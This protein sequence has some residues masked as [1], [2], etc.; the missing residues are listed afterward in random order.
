MDKRKQLLNQE[1]YTA[2]AATPTVSK[3]RGAGQAGGAAERALPGRWRRPPS[4]EAAQRHRGRLNMRQKARLVPHVQRQAQR[5]HVVAVA[6][7][8][9]L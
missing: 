2:Q 4:G 5:G 1:Q 9:A 8:D 6:A 7:Q 3:G